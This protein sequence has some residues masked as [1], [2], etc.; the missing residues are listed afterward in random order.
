MLFINVIQTNLTLNYE[1]IR[2]EC[3]RQLNRIYY[4][5]ES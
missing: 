3:N 2:G 5:I 1:I 4:E